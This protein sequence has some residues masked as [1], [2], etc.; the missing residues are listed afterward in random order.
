MAGQ[1]VV[2]VGSFQVVENV[3]PGFVYLSPL[4][5]LLLFVHNSYL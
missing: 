3:M 2:G 4:R 1:V 5:V